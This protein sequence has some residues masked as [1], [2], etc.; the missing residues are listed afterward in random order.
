MRFNFHSAQLAGGHCYLRY[1]D[2]NPEKETKEFIDN[3]GENVKWL[4]YTPYKVTYAS[5]Y[6]EDLYNLAVYLIKRGKAFV[7]HQT[8]Q[9]MNDY[10]EKKMDSPYRTRSVEENVKL[11]EMMRQGRFDEKE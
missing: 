7:C 10:R 11:F 4:G 9:E 5:D 6:F 1:D 3:I 8:K 2:T